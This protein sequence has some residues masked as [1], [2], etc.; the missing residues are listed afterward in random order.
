LSEGQCALG[1]RQTQAQH[2]YAAQRDDPVIA[3]EISSSLVS[4]RV[5]KGLD[6]GA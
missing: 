1:R 3:H 6:E 2:D 4:Q 5:G